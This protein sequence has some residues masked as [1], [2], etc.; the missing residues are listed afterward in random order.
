MSA[1]R[2]CLRRSAPSSNADAPMHGDTWLIDELFVSIKGQRHYLWR[3]IDQDAD[4][5]DILL[6]KLRN[7]AAAKRFFRRLLTSER[8]SPNRLVTDKLGSYRA[9]QCEAGLRL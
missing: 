7:A 8:T 2:P 4:E 5:I 3:A 9:H 1:F 6:Q